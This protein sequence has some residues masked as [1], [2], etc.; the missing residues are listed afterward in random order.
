VCG[1]CSYTPCCDFR[2]TTGD[3]WPQLGGGVADLGGLARRMTRCSMFLPLARILARIRCS[4]APMTTAFSKRRAQSPSAAQAPA[5][6]GVVAQCVDGDR[7][8]GLPLQKSAAHAAQCAALFGKNR[9]FWTEKRILSTKKRS[10]ALF[11]FAALRFF[12]P[13]P[14]KRSPPTKSAA[15]DQKAQRGEKKRKRSGNTRFL[16]GQ[17]AFLKFNKITHLWAH[18]HFCRWNK[19]A[20]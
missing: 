8:A 10:A 5:D 7:R 1:C 2:C 3:L 18:A 16:F 6:P 9:T 14:E 19:K 4:A 20:R 12:A 11:F 13:Q 17:R 15:T